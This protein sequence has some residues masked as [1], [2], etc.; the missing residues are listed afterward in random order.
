M[1][2][3]RKNNRKLSQVTIFILMYIRLISIF[4]I[5]WEKLII[6]AALLMQTVSKYAK[7]T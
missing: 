1:V 7:R 6:V 2:K 4:A 5:F 3:K